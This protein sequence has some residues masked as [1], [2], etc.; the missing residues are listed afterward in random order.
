MLLKNLDLEGSNMLVN[1]SRGVVIGF[2]RNVTGILVDWLRKL[3]K[4]KMDSSPG[5]R[6][7][8]LRIRSKLEYVL[9]QQNPMFPIVRFV[10]G[11]EEVIT[12]G[13]ENHVTIFF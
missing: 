7:E 11:R 13:M 12:P 10:N 6:Y 4:L 5:A 8:S 1:G 3:N 9:E 2:E